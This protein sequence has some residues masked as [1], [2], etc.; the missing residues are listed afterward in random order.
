[1]GPRLVDPQHDPYGGLDP[2]PLPQETLFGGAKNKYRKWGICQPPVRSCKEFMLTLL[3]RIVC[4]P[5]G[6][7][8]STMRFRTYQVKCRLFGSCTGR[9]LDHTMKQALHGAR[10]LQPRVSSVVC[11]EGAL[12][13]ALVRG[14]GTGW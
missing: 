1:M 13:L 9:Q 7:F 3:L 8:S 10:L 11:F 2:E 12:A 6:C 5:F 4:S 14:V